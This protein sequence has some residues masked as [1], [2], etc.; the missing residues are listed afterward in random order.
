MLVADRTP[1]GSSVIIF[2]PDPALG[3][4]P[5][6]SSR[7]GWWLIWGDWDS[8]QSLLEGLPLHLAFC[9]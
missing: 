6:T 7:L 3:I 9:F 4:P 2:F 1:G 8:T 5:P